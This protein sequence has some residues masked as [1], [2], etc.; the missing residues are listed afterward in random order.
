MRYSRLFGKTVRDKPR[1]ADSESH[2]L[3]LRGGFVRP[4]SGGGFLLLPLG[5]RVME[6]VQAIVAEEIEQCGASVL[7][8]PGGRQSANS[9][10][11]RSLRLR[12][13]AARRGYPLPPPH[14]PPA[15]P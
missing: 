15:A 12:R 10:L 5:Q 3:L 11:C 7:G 8:F 14:A 6:K 1:N 9:D 2:Q 4:A 13:R